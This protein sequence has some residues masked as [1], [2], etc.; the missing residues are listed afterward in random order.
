LLAGESGQTAA[1]PL[2]ALAGFECDASIKLGTVEVQQTSTSPPTW[3]ANFSLVPAA[4]G[5]HGITAQYL[6]TTPN[7]PSSAA[8]S[9]NVN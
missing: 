8:A 2:Q 3:T 5:T 7:A 9:I 1:L 4:A 6:G